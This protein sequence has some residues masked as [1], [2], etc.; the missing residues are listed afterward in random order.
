MPLVLHTPAMALTPATALTPWRTW[1]RWHVQDIYRKDAVI[2]KLMNLAVSGTN[3]QTARTPSGA[4]NH[5]LSHRSLS[6]FNVVG[7]M[8]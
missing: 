7:K 5:T 1:L 4:A 2:G 3:V 8:S 6:L